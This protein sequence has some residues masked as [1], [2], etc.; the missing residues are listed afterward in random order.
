MKK[1]VIITGLCIAIAYACAPANTGSQTFSY[2]VQA[3]SRTAPTSA[4]F[5]VTDGIDAGA[6]I[7]LNNIDGFRVSVCAAE[8]GTTLGASG[9][10]QAWLW[11]ERSNEV[12]RNNDLDWTIDSATHC[13]VFPDQ[14]VKGP[15]GRVLYAASSALVQDA[16]TLLPDAGTGAFVVRIQGWKAQ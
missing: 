13:Q 4:S 2:E 3:S 5:S 12:M 8:T 7:S 14:E 10:L 1:A 15:F 9:S 11:D 6:S 16:G